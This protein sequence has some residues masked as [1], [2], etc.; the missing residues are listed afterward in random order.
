[1]KR[2]TGPD[3]ARTARRPSE[4]MDGRF[5]A[6]DQKADRHFTRLVGIQVAVLVAIVG[7]LVGSYYQ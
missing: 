6:L 3:I 7:A 5:E 2:S 1:M 4:Q